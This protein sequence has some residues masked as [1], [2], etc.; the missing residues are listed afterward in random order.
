[1]PLYELGNQEVGAFV[2]TGGTISQFKE[3][4][5]KTK[6]LTR[7]WISG[8][9]PDAQWVEVKMSVWGNAPDWCA[10]GVQV[11]IGKLEVKEFEGEIQ[12]EIKEWGPVE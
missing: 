1:M 11:L 10:D 9:D 12:F 8:Q 5:P 7:V 2:C 3:E 6:T 4:T